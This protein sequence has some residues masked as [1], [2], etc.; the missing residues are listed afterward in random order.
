[1][2]TFHFCVLW[3]TKTGFLDTQQLSV[4]GERQADAFRKLI[5]MVD[6]SIA[7]WNESPAIM[8]IHFVSSY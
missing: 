6:S 7:S 2:F 1:M 5:G 8:P 4:R 3:P